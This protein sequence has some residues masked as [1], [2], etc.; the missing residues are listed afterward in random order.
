MTEPIVYP[1]A[2]KPSHRIRPDLLGTVI[3]AEHGTLVRWAVPAHQP[4][5]PLHSH[6]EFEQITVILEGRIRTRVGDEYFVL[7][8]GDLVRIARGA[9]HGNTTALGD[10]DAVVLDIF[11]PPR[12]QYVEAAR[13]ETA[14]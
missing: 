12:A 7:G 3:P 9:M 5:T 1:A 14:P 6:I 10:A 13:I 11:M 4:E 8:P 2:D